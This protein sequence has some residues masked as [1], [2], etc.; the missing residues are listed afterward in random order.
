VGQSVRMS[1]GAS[2][3]TGSSDKSIKLRV[4]THG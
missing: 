3:G 1:P 4:R 2:E